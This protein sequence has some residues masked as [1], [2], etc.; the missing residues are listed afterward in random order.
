MGSDEG[1]GGGAL[2]L[3]HVLDDAPE[4]VGDRLTVVETVYHQPEGEEPTAVESRYSRR[5][6][7]NEQLFQRRCRA[8]AQ[9][10]PLDTGWV[11]AAGLLV[12]ENREGRF[13]QRRPTDAERLEAAAR[14]L[15]ITV[16]R[17]STMHAAPLEPDWFVLP[18]ES[19]RGH[20]AKLANLR[21][22]CQADGG[23]RFTV[24]IVPE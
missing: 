19:M 8:G 10:Q 4:P 12:I 2:E 14:I 18:G 22:R 9:W 15:E 3:G 16:E 7:T 20:P 6:L 17:D 1:S 13:L 11:D 24:S 23:A 5:L 21:V